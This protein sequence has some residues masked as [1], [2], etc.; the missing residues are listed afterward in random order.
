MATVAMSAMMWNNPT[1]KTLLKVIMSMMTTMTTVRDLENDW[2][3]F[4]FHCTCCLYSGCSLGGESR[5]F[6][7]FQPFHASTQLAVDLDSFLSG[8]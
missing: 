7:S 3:N 5:R 2:S 1:R 6:T 4:P 8:I